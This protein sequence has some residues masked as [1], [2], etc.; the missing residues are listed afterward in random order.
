[1][2]KKKNSGGFSIPELLAVIVIM[3]I[4]ITIATASYNGISRSLKQKT[5]DNK[6][7]LIKTK[8]I[9]YAMDNKVDVG[10]ISVATLLQEGYLD[11]DANLEDEYGNNKLSNPLG[12]YLDCYKIDINKYID[13]Y[14]VDITNDNSCE[15]AELAVLSSKLD[16]EIY[17]DKG[18]NLKQYGLGKNENTEWTN[19][20][21]Y[22]F[23]NPK[24]L[25]DNKLS[26]D[27]MK[28]SWLVNGDVITYSGSLASEVTKAKGYANIYKVSTLLLF[29]GEVTVKVETIKGVLTKSVDVKIDKESPKVNLSADASFSNS[30]KRIIFN[31]NDGSGSG[32]DEYAYALEDDVKKT[33]IFKYK[34][35]NGSNYVDVYENKTYY[36]YAKDKAGN[37]SDSPTEIKITNI[38]NKVPVCNI[39]AGQEGWSRSYTYT[40]GCRND[41]GSGCATPSTTETI[42]TDTDKINL[43]WNIKDNIGNNETCSTNLQAHVDVTAPTCQIVISNNSVKG[44]NNWYT[45]DV[46]VNLVANDNLSGIAEKGLSTSSSEDYNGV[47]QIVLRND[48]ERSGITYYGYVKDKAGNTNR[49][50]LNVKRLAEKPICVVNAVGGN[51]GTEWYVSDVNTSVSSVSKYVVSTKIK[52]NNNYYNNY[53]VNYNTAG[54]TIVGE[55]RNDAGT[56]NTCTKYIKR[57]ADAPDV[58]FTFQKTRENYEC[59]TYK[60]KCND[61]EAKITIKG[62]VSGVNFAGVS[63]HSS[64]KYIGSAAD[65]DACVAKYTNKDNNNGAVVG[66]AVVGG[67]ASGIVGAT[68]GA[69]GAGAGAI[70]GAITGGLFDDFSTSLYRSICMMQ[71]YWDKS[72]WVYNYYDSPHTFVQ[73]GGQTETYYAKVCSNAKVC[74]EVLAEITTPEP[75]QENNSCGVLTGIVGGAGAGYVAGNILAGFLGPVGF[76]AGLIGGA[77]VGGVICALS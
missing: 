69:A 72:K 77:V 12:G 55:V 64:S 9:E 37:V 39:P 57:D 6:I 45:S 38:D 31:G 5:Y 46:E 71:T 14:D 15:L 74:K 34:S 10:T 75:K 68:A 36:A 40:Y 21:V 56:T 25:N 1:M 23:L 20:D 44:E 61:V 63:D 70:A 28:I 18:D 66:G 76:L 24:A 65:I 52:K 30:K 73:E 17:A 41:V 27:N 11:M 29:N 32:F 43:N 60:N 58:D 26:T 19:K 8:A 16:I 51:N 2:M 59:D 7:S 49:C 22:L 33:P 42:T 13:D 4:L 3:G 50:E 47:E 48:T 35:D 53:T 62:S 54:E 67:V